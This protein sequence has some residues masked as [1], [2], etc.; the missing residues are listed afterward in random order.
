MA[1][2]LARLI[3]SSWNGPLWVLRYLNNRGRLCQYA[4]VAT[5][6]TNEG[7]VWRY[8]EGF[9]ELKLPEGL[10]AKSC[11]INAYFTSVLTQCG[12]LYTALHREKQVV[13]LREEVV[14]IVARGDWLAVLD[15]RQ[16]LVVYT[17]FSNP[18]KQW[19]SDFPLEQFHI[20]ERTDV[21][22]IA[23]SGY[24]SCFYLTADREGCEIRTGATVQFPST[25]VGFYNLNG[26]LRFLY[27]NGESK[28]FWEGT[29]SPLMIQ[30]IIDT[31]PRPG[32]IASSFSLWMTENNE[33][34]DDGGRQVPLGD[35]LRERWKRCFH[36]TIK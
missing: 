28:Q 3:P 6:V 5:I 17:W 12:K 16:E 21:I 26:E 31:H 15:E 14:K 19:K 35:G 8:I 2:R 4:G 34:F 32:C 13:L 10:R 20:I 9:V 18:D 22:D 23:E 7:R 29:I 33:V 25:M 24:N 27:E 30:S 11:A 36:F 1:E